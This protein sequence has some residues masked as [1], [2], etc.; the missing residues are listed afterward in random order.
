MENGNRGERVI[1]DFGAEWSRF[2][3]LEVSDKSELEAQAEL[4]LAPVK[5]FL[6]NC[7][8]KIV[9]ADFG[10]GS[11]RWSEYLLP[12]AS[13][14]IVIEP[15]EGAFLTLKE[16][17][18]DRPKVKLLNKTIEDCDLESE[19][20][21]LAVS[22]GVIHHIPSPEGAIK[23]IHSKLKP[24]GTFLCYLYYNFE[25]RN[26]AFVL[27]WRFS[28]YLRLLISKLPQR[29]K[30]MVCDVIAVTV[31]F[32]LAKLGK[33]LNALKLDVK[34]LPL[35]HYKNLP[36]KVLRN[37]AL[38]RFGTRIE[39]RFSRSEIKSMFSAAGFNP[40]K[41]KFSEEEPFWTFSA[42]KTSEK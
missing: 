5:E 42:V 11:G 13:T 20:I 12:F 3:F 39:Q 37:D 22:L 8:E 9:I 10:A 38:D 2:K 24:S 35:S 1:S 17:F 21:D 36:F 19:S 15:S 30:F 34:N 41:I 28:N 27:L 16:R 7:K 25:G 40:T 26:A 4:Y 33:L 32:P 14:L 31:Y 6:E 29:A 18:K 23:T